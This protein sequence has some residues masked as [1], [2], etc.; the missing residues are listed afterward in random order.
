M[1][2]VNYLDWRLMP[3]TIAP[4]ES[5]TPA[6]LRAVVGK[7]SRRLTALA[8]GAGLTPTQLS[9]LGVVARHGPLRITELA[10]LEDLNPTMASR[11]LAVLEDEG[12]VRR[13][14]DPTDRRAAR[15]ETTALGRRTHDRLR[16]QR[17]KVLADAL[18]VLAPGDVALIEAALPALEA[19]TDAA[20]SRGSGR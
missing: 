18:G 3:A 16:Q 5:E 6:R 11:V 8:R 19:L 13:E 14:T 2:A 15:V 1:P 20:T 9:V 10:A 4:V 17:G 12:L 7:L